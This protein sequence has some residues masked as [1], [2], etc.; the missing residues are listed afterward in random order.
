M[1]CPLL[2]PVIQLHEEFAGNCTRSPLST[3]IAQS[4]YLQSFLYFRSTLT[5]LRAFFDHAGF[6]YY[7]C[8][9]PLQY[10]TAKIIATQI[11]TFTKC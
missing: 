9:S 8:L 5:P 6:N 11:V 1:P 3:Q 4:I 2:L 10:Y 7:H